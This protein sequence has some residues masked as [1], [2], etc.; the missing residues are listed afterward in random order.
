MPY[1]VLCP[2]GKV[3]GLITVVAEHFHRTGFRLKCSGLLFLRVPSSV[4]LRASSQD[5]HWHARGLYGDS[6]VV[7]CPWYMPAF[8]IMAACGT[9][10]IQGAGGY[11]AAGG[12]ARTGFVH[13]HV[14]KLVC[15]AHPAAVHGVADRGIVG[16][17]FIF[18][19]LL[20]HA[21]DLAIMTIARNVADH[22]TFVFIRHGRM[23]RQYGRRDGPVGA[24]TPRPGPP[25]CQARPA[26][27]ERTIHT[28]TNAA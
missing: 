4:W 25:L 18:M 28:C 20:G 2:A 14:H 26:I 3:P 23:G 24:R 16:S 6:T 27:M 9:L 7:S 22:N 5:P 17:A 13:V 11:L 12:V 15:P 1:P 21:A 19:Q 10:P 8:M